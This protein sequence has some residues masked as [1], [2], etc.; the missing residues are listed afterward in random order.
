[1]LEISLESFQ[2]LQTRQHV[3]AQSY[4]PEW[5]P[6]GPEIISVLLTVLMA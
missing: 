1:M 3:K 2:F 5:L 6:E 4:E